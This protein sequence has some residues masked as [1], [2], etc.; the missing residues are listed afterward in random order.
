M[1]LIIPA[2]V[3]QLYLNNGI[4]EGNQIISKDWVMKSTTPQVAIS[5]DT[6]FGYLFWMQEF[7]GERSYFMTGTGGNKVAIFPELELVVVLTSTNYRGGMNAHHQT[8]RIL[9]DYIVPEI[10]NIHAKR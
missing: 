10:I 8:E 9:S 4:W 2:K 1:G 5:E 6:E 7:G 3:C